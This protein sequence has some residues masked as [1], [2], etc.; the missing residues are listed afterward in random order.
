MIANRI[1]IRNKCIIFSHN[2]LKSLFH[3]YGFSLVFYLLIESFDFIFYSFVTFNRLLT[4]FLRLDF[5][6]KLFLCRC[7]SFSLRYNRPCQYINFISKCRIFF[8]KF[9]LTFTISSSRLNILSRFSSC[10]RRLCFLPQFI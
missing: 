2:K 5:I 4:Y 3:R 10:D 6:V 8:C 7:D 1:N 9:L